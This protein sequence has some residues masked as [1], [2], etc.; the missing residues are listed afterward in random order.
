[1]WCQRALDISR[2]NGDTLNIAWA[3]VFLGVQYIAQPDSYEQAMAF[4]Q[5]GLSLFRALNHKAGIAQALNILGELARG[6][7]DYSAAQDYYLEALPLT[8]EIGERIR[9]YMILSNLGYVAYHEGDYRRAEAYQ[10]EC[11]QVALGIFNPVAVAFGI[12]N[13]AGAIAANGDPELA[14]RLTAGM[15]TYLESV[16]VRH[17]PGDQFERDHYK[18]MMRQQLGEEA[19]ERAW[20]AGQTMTLDEAI[21][22]VLGEEALLR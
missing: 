19:F 3:L 1:M 12:I 17:Q 16:R 4:C 13:L 20:A 8:R 6:D 21:I 11:L 22:E 18:M 15:E 9:V 5:E 7:G 2:A 14:A 10:R